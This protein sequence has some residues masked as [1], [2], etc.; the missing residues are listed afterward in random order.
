MNNGAAT[1]GDFNSQQDNLP[2]GET[3]AKFLLQVG[4]WGTLSTQ[5]LRAFNQDEADA[6][7]ASL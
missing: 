7:I 1:R 3:V 2:D 6:L 4:S 5:T